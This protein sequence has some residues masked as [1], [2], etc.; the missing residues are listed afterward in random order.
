MSLMI[1]KMQNMAILFILLMYFGNADEKQNVL[2][3]VV[4]DLRPE[5]HKPYDQ[6]FLHTPNLDAF[7]KESLT[8]TRAYTQYAHCS[9]SRNSFLSGR[10]PQTAGVY[11]FIDDF[12]S[13]PGG[14]GEN[15]TSLPQH[16]KERGGYWTVGGGKVFHPN[17]PKD[18]DMPK[19]WTKYTVK[20][21]DDAGCRLNETLYSGVCPT[22]RPDS[23]FYDN[24]LVKNIVTQMKEGKERGKPFFLAAGIRR[25][26]RPWNVPDRFYDMYDKNTLPLAK[27]KHSPVNMP[28]LAYIYNSWPPTFYNQTAPVSDNDASYGRLGYYA[29]VSFT[30][31]N[32]G[33]LL[34]GLEDN[35]LTSSTVVAIVSDHGWHLG[36]QGEWCK[37]T[38]FELAT[39]IPVMIR[40]PRHPNTFGK[41]TA[42]FFELL[43]LYKTL[44]GLTKA[45]DNVESGVEGKDLTGVFNNLNV[46]PIR[47]YAFSQMARCPQGDTLGPNS[48]CN[49]VQRKDIKYMGFTV[50]DNRWRYTAWLKF[51]GAENKATWST[52]NEQNNNVI[53]GEELYDH[54]NDTGIDFDKYENINVNK[55]Y[56]EV[57]KR[58]FHVLKNQFDSNSR[59]KTEGINSMPPKPVFNDSVPVFYPGLNGSKCFRIPTMIKTSSGTLLAFA[60][61]RD[62]SCHDSKPPH[63]IVLRRSFDDGKSWGPLILVAEDKVAPCKKCPKVPSNPNSVEITLNDGR[64][65]ILLHFDTMNNPAH[66]PGQDHGLDLQMLSYDEGLTWSVPSKLEFAGKYAYENYGAL[67]G[68][69]NGIFNKETNVT[70]FTGHNGYES[71]GFLYFSNSNDR[72]KWTMSKTIKGMNECSIAFLNATMNDRIIMSCRTG[73]ANQHRRAKLIFSAHGELIGNIEYPDIYDNDPGCQGSII[74]GGGADNI[75]YT[76]N[77]NDYTDRKN[78]TI[79]RSLNGGKSWDIFR[80]VWEGPSGYSQLTVLNENELGLIFECGRIGFKDTISFVKIQVK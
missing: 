33:I 58:L 50:R 45:A 19:S 43:D 46:N 12:R 15:W 70:Y 75:L 3:I 14:T 44:N 8:F 55:Q 71:G 21:G 38:N 79:K 52:R 56:P 18:N 47:E 72:T 23:W 4:D 30:D 32:I 7:A 6:T 62:Q 69:S 11:N 13:A 61:N 76:S 80:N 29:S 27:K 10:S 60:E 42:H 34:K 73:V 65:A 74:N 9:P 20:N 67:I 26:H 1:I 64:K 39:R 36:E 63:Q 37:R 35:N 17:H 59:S 51:N 77:A 31:H 57:S 48:A 2:L 41:S 66:R 22:K 5:L 53:Y 16:F 54:L 24:N 49:E 40:S 68:P 78:M 25:P 28:E